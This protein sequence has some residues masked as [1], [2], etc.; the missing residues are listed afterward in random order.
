MKKLT[1]TLMLM[2]AYWLGGQSITSHT[3]WGEIAFA[4]QGLILKHYR[5]YPYNYDPEDNLLT[6]EELADLNDITYDLAWIEN[7]QL[8]YQLSRMG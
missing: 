7:E 2:L 5:E 1:K 4:F 8:D 6:D 3:K